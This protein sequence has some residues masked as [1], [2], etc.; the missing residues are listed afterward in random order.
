MKENRYLNDFYSHYDEEERLASKHGM[1]EF[2]TTMRYIEKY[3]K[4]DD[5]ILEI[6]AGTGRYS[7]A[8]AKQG[9]CVDA[10]ELVE[11]NIDVFKQNT[12]AGEK[13]P[14]CREMHWICLIFQITIMI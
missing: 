7:H 5:K 6:G 3:I 13:L 14:S 1:A 2:L 8:L 10:V 11:H 9:Y 12:S 4:Q